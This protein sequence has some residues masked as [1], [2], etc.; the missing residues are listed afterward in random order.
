MIEK[1]MKPEQKSEDNGAE[2]ET[3]MIMRMPEVLFLKIFIIYI[4]L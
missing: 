4:T 1:K 2:L 3:Q